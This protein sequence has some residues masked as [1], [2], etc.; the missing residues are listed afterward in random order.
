MRWP[1]V[2]AGL[3]WVALALGW[4]AG[5]PPWLMWLGLVAAVIV[6]GMAIARPHG[7]N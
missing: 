7:P 2:T 5:N 4:L 6:T 1:W 3:L